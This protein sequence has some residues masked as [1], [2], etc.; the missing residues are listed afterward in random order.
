MPSSIAYGQSSPRVSPPLGVQAAYQVAALIVG[1]TLRV[2]GK[3]PADS[4]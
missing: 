2:P 4:A 1:D 3:G